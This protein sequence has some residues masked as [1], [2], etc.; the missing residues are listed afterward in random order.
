MI[1]ADSYNT[2]DFLKSYESAVGRKMGMVQYQDI[3][4]ICDTG[5]IQ[6]L[7]PAVDDANLSLLL[8]CKRRTENNTK[9]HVD[10]CFIDNILL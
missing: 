1:A 7:A 10:W 8:L 3:R 6:T 9:L 2:S 4:W 5:I